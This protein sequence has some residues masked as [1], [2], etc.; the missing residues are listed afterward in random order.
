MGNFQYSVSRHS[1]ESRPFHADSTAPD[2]SSHGL[3]SSTGIVPGEKVGGE[4]HAPVRELSYLIL[5]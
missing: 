5:H 4:T 3:P 2:G 1:T